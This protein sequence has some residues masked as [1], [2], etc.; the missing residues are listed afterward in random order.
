M[1][2]NEGSGWTV[3]SSTVENE[4]EITPSATADY[5]VTYENRTSC[6]VTIDVVDNLDINVVVGDLICSTRTKILTATVT[7][8]TAPY[9]YEINGGAYQSENEFDV[10]AGN[11]IVTVKDNNDCVSSSVPTGVN[12]PDLVE[13]VTLQ[14]SPFTTVCVDEASS[15]TLTAAPTSTSS[16]INSY[17]WKKD[18]IV[19]SSE[20]ADVYVV[21][22]S[23]LNEVGS[24]VFEVIGEGECQSAPVSKTIIVKECFELPTAITPYDRS[25]GNDIFAQ[26]RGT[27]LY[28]FNRY[29][30]SVYEEKVN[31]S[32]DLKGWNGCWT[33][34]NGKEVD[35]GVYFYVLTTADETLKG[36]VEVVK[37]K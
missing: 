21:P 23:D 14:V 9:Q 19:L 1:K 11:Y 18:G 5:R 31:N 37:T 30:V 22:S 4:I 26:A 10:A 32:S 24:F 36:T 12:I 33:G 13:Q 35:P 29:G 16:A 7:G 27:E 15:V 25:S 6:S 20:T 2:K 28:V 34:E 3:I 8:G 17:I